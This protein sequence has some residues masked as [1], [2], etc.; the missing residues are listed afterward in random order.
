MRVAVLIVVSNGSAVAESVVR[1]VHSAGLDLI[2]R[3]SVNDAG[4]NVILRYSEGSSVPR[5]SARSFGVPQDDERVATDSFSYAKIVKCGLATAVAQD[6]THLITLDIDR[7]HA[8]S[9]LP[10]L[11]AAIERSPDAIINGVRQQLPLAVKLAR[12]NGDFWTACITGRWIRDGAFGYRAYPL[13]AVADLSVRSVGRE[14]DLEILVKSI[15]AG[16]AVVQIPIAIQKSRAW[17]MSPVEFCR[18]GWLVVTLLAQRLILPALLRASIHQ[19]S[20]GDQPWTRRVRT[21]LTQ[22]IL[23][24]CDRPTKFA[25]AVGIGV[26]F[27]VTPVWGFQIFFAAMTAHLLR[28]SRTVAVAASTISS[29]LTIPVILYA[30]LLAGRAVRGRPVAGLPRPSLIDRLFILQSLGD[31]L[32]GSLVVGITAGL[33]VGAITA[34]IAGR[35]KARRTRKA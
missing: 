25:A 17:L 12:F 13:P 8:P 23:H 29:P 19:R 20:A 4:A 5:E 22:A 14:C 27:G 24:H 7:G 32:I 16:A 34:I 31:Y 15:W 21:A 6:F 33:I 28:L 30:S 35:V 2:L 11:L 3:N 18:F 1:E 26:F 9:D 10:A